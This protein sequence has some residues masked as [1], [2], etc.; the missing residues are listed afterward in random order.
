MEKGVGVGVIYVKGNCNVIMIKE[1]KVKELLKIKDNGNF[2]HRESQVLEFKEQFSLSALAEYFRDFAAFANNKGGYLIFGVKDCPY[3]LKGLTEK[4]QKQFEKIDP[5]KI[6]G[7]LLDIF[8]PNISWL[9]S[10]IVIDS[11]KF[12]IFYINEA[13][14]KPIIAKKNEGKEQI[15]KNGEVYYRYYGRT[16]KIEFA[17]LQSIINKRLV[18]QTQQWQSLISKIAKVGPSNVAILDAERGVIEKNDA[19]VLVIDKELAKKIKFIKEGAFSEKE[20][21]TTLKL[22]GNVQPIDT[23][24]VTKIKTQKLI[25]E[26]PYSALGLADEVKER[27]SNIGQGDVW[28]IIA[29]NNLKNNTDYSAY[30]FHNK[31]QEDKYKKTGELSKSIPSIYNNEAVEFIIKIFKNN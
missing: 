23:V 1:S 12:G 13:E 26:Y 22:V 19:Q 21:K 20:G 5:E 2:Y 9:Q 11:R 30:N 29:E 27:L 16:Q 24:E 14:V 7:F 31:G 3:T 8:S 4:S 6:T 25:E 28:K 10:T 18:L 15:I 17:E